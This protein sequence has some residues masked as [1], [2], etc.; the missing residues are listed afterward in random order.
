MN[1]N[2]FITLLVVGSLVG[3]ITLI[4]AK[5]TQRSVLLYL[6]VSIVGALL[7]WWI[8]QHINPVAIQVGFAIG[9]SLALLSVLRLFKK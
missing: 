5:N 7:G 8:L 2:T 4:F 9:G 6:A 1:L 3:C